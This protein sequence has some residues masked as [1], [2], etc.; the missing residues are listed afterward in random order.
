MKKITL[1]SILM[2]TAV[3]LQAQNNNGLMQ[4]MKAM[5]EETDPAKSMQLMKKII[6]DNN[7][8]EEKD[9][10]TI[11]MM[12]GEVAMDYLQAGKYSEFENCIA[13]MRNK[14]NQTSYLNMGATTLAQQKK[15]LELAERLSK[16]TLDLYN[17][18]KDDPKAR[19][20]DMP[21]ADWKRFM[22]F[23]YFPY[24]DTYAMALHARGKNKEA[25][26]YQEKAMNGSPEEAMPSS[27]ERY[28]T[29][30]KLNNQ[31]DKAYSLLLQMAK[32]GKSTSGMN[33]LLKELYTKKN[34]GGAGFDA[35]FEDLQ[36]NVVVSLKEEF[37]KKMQD[38][39]APGFTLK[40][41][42]GNNVSLSDFKGKTVVIDFWATWCM[43]CIAS[44]P[45]MTKIMKQHPE[46]KFLYIATQEK[47]NGA[48]NRVKSFI[49]KNQY[50]FHV[51]LDEPLANNAQMFEALSA[52]K[53]Q[54]IPAKVIIDPKGKQRFLTIGFSSDTQLINEMEA[55]IQ[56]IQDLG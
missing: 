54:G 50:P 20:N 42:D 53:P 23:A 22:T 56:L 51:L 12:K 34:N 11:D 9:A 49:T 17:S 8:Q 32:T 44:F 27:V 15:D 28:A 24:C 48:L 7:L 38:I 36:K 29:L 5:R 2:I 39:D 13:T 19:P 25:L 47:Q 1:L 4:Q 31:E 52:Y 40:D 16:K 37:R 55:M 46:V 35:F 14:F 18:F 10:E 26:L 6:K 3:L 21:E 33:D 43:P 30:L 45:A 41:L